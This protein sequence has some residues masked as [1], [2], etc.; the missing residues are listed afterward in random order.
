MKPWA[1]PTAREVLSGPSISVSWKINA[2]PLDLIIGCVLEDDAMWLLNIQGK[3]QPGT[4]VVL[5]LSLVSYSGYHS[6]EN[7][8]RVANAITVQ[9]MILGSMI[10][11]I[12]FGIFSRYHFHTLL[13]KQT[14]SSNLKSL[15]W[16]GDKFTRTIIKKCQRK[17][18]KNCQPTFIFKH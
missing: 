18:K 1:F 6:Q 13:L 12:G 4:R 10:E 11:S 3:S 17:R 14:T 8:C 2:P 9:N 16:I 7:C 15:I 5:W